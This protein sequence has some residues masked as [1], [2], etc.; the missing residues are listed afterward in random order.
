MPFSSM[1][2]LNCN[3]TVG[4]RCILSPENMCLPCLPTNNQIY[5]THQELFCN[6][7]FSSG[8]SIDSTSIA[9]RTGEFRYGTVPYLTFLTIACIKVNYSAFHPF[10]RY[11][12]IASR[13]LLNMCINSG[14]CKRAAPC[15]KGNTNYPYVTLDTVHVLQMDKICKTNP[16]QHTHTF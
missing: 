7:I 4:A 8:E 1:F 14:R 13:P 16:F 12:S 9:D 6:T 10:L 15:K 5:N 3:H 2:Y 11:W